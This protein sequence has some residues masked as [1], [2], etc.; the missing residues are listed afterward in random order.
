MLK[1]WYT[2]LGIYL[3]SRIWQ[4]I[5]D[6]G[7]TCSVLPRRRKTPRIRD[8][9]SNLCVCKSSVKQVGDIWIPPKTQIRNAGTQTDELGDVDNNLSTDIE[10]NACSEDI[11]TIQAQWVK[12]D[13]DDEES[14]EFCQ[15]DKEEKPHTATYPLVKK[16]TL[17][18]MK[19]CHG[20]PVTMT[21]ERHR[22]TRHLS[23]NDDE[24]GNV[25]VMNSLQ[26]FRIKSRGVV[27]FGNRR[28][29]FSEEITVIRRWEVEDISLFQLETQIHSDRVIEQS[30]YS[31]QNSGALNCKGTTGH[32]FKNSIICKIP[33]S[34]IRK[35]TVSDRNQPRLTRKLKMGLG[36]MDASNG[37]TNCLSIP[38]FDTRKI[39]IMPSHVIEENYVSVRS[40]KKSS[41]NDTKNNALDDQSHVVGVG[42]NPK[43]GAG[44]E[45]RSRGFKRKERNLVG[46]KKRGNWHFNSN[47]AET[48]LQENSGMDASNV[49]KTRQQEDSGMGASNVTKTRLQEESGIDASNV[50]KTRL[51]GYSGM[52]ASNV[53]KARLHEDSGMEASNVTKTRLQEESGMEASNVT[54][55]NLQEDSGMDTSNVTRTRLQVESGMDTSNVTRTRLQEESGMD[56]SNVTKTRPQEDSGMDASNVTKTRLQGDSG[57]DA[58]NVTKTRLQEDSGIDALQLDNRICGNLTTQDERRF[59]QVNAND[60]CQKEK[61]ITKPK[62]KQKFAEKLY[63]RKQSNG[64]DGIGSCFKTYPVCWCMVVLML[65]PTT[66]ADPKLHWKESARNVTQCPTTKEEWLKFSTSKDCSTYLSEPQPQYHCVLND[67]RTGF[68]ELCAPVRKIMGEFCTEY[69]RGLEGIQPQTRTSCKG[70]CPFAYNSTDMIKYPECYNLSKIYDSTD[71]ELP[72]STAVTKFQENSTTVQQPSKFQTSRYTCD[73]CSAIAITYIS[74]CTCILLF[75]FGLYKY[76]KVRRPKHLYKYADVTSRVHD[77][78]IILQLHSVGNLQKAT[79]V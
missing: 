6:L 1:H 41:Q 78:T 61:R 75:G 51:Q 49:T 36:G 64:S 29:S 35:V 31:F 28:I 7:R 77:G 32:E 42:C 17:D 40:E 55:T 33:N 34:E 56:A 57:M 5:Y 20:C 8:K 16:T 14:R 38:N 74:I 79:A 25:V 11:S 53:T 27:E 44:F 72:I 13:D 68:V 21:T 50:T 3:W 12:E 45:K 39:H 73:A 71:S 9:K 54:K 65:L 47:I 30:V 52:E 37:H 23:Y 76:C 63:F 66:A 19:V 10:E 69:N 22:R 24:N 60:H 62:V 59:Q 70:I 4:W 48:R 26:E 18:V 67:D 2:L 15:E 58:S 43:T 46:D